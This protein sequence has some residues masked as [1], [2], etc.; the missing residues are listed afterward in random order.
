[1]SAALP[2]FDAEGSPLERRFREFHEHNPEVYRMLV[3][4]AREAKAR[5]RKRYGIGALW[6]VLRW[7]RDVETH[8]DRWKLNNDFRAPMARLIERQEPDLRGFFLM[9][10]TDAERCGS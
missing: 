2:L 10:R 7:R 6:E 5:G 8:G 4:M 1:V 3:E 9:R